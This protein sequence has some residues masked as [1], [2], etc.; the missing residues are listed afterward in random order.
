MIRPTRRA[1]KLIFPRSDAISTSRADRIWTCDGAPIGGVRAARVSSPRWA[2]PHQAAPGSCRSA[3]GHRADSGS[4]WPPRSSWAPPSG[5]GLA[6]NYPWAVVSGLCAVSRTPQHLRR[7][8][9]GMADLYGIHTPGVAFLT[10][11]CR[12]RRDSQGYLAGGVS[13]AAPGVVH[14]RR[15]WLSVGMSVVVALTVPRLRHAQLLVPM[16]CP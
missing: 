1:R 3:S 9:S 12:P 10:P 14:L 11:Y 15:G 2:R 4:R 13:R 7:H 6:A 16:R 5:S 8:R